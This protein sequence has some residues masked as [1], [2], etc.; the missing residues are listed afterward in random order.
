MSRSL[1]YIV[2][3]DIRCPRRLGRVH[4][5]L[6]RRAIALQ[7]SVFIARLDKPGREL[8][9]RDLRVIIHPQQDDIRLYPLP[10]TPEWTTLGK[11]LWADGVHL[12]GVKLPPRAV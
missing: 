5:Y 8:L 2:C 3:Y 12:T 11:A 7:Y 10:E 6:K 9:M 1:S 4:R